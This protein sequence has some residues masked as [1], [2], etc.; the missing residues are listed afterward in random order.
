MAHQANSHG[1]DFSVTLK[2][3]TLLPGTAAEGHLTMTS[4]GQHDI[5]GCVAALIATEQWK[6]HDTERDANGNSHQVTRTVTKELQRL[7]VM[8]VGAGAL[9]AGQPQEMDFQVPVPPLGP[10]TFEGDVIR[11]TWELEIKLDVGGMD[12]SMIRDSRLLDA[13]Y[14]L[15]LADTKDFA[16]IFASL[17]VR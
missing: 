8:L 14:F 2:R 17:P 9:A 7:P 5:R 11:L 16:A 6:Y 10:A 15:H 13:N 1:V 3:E 4:S 12:P